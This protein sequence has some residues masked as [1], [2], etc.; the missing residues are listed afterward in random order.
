MTPPTV[1]T[2]H[3]ASTGPQAMRGATLIELLIAIVVVA[4]LAGLVFRAIGYAPHDAR[5]QMTRVTLNSC[6]NAIVGSA[7]A[8]AVLS[9]GYLADMGAV[10][11]QVAD[12][13]RL[14]AGAAAFDP[15]TGFGWRGPYL[16]V[17]GAVFEPDPVKGFGFQYGS[18]NDPAVKDGWDRP[19]VLQIPHP[20]NSPTNESADDRRHARL[21]SAGPDGIL[22]T[23]FTDATSGGGTLSSYFPP[24]P[25]CGD[26]LVL[27][28]QVTDL[29]APGP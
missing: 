20:D 21:I 13:L 26:D 14:P 23:P 16:L 25:L 4:A 8:G 24:K 1:T 18:L 3:A 17:N 7:S 27:Y 28:V 9:A 2:V 5:T 6:R 15:A 11:T 10:P 19:I 29:R 22:Q 12:L